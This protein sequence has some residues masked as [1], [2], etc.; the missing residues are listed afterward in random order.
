MLL[1]S[2]HSDGID[3]S[4]VSRVS[5]GT[6]VGQLLVTDDDEVSTSGPAGQRPSR[7]WAHR[8][9]R[10]GDRSFRCTRSPVRDACCS[11]AARAEIVREHVVLVVANPAPVGPESPALVELADVLIVNEL[12]AEM[13]LDFPDSKARPWAGAPCERSG[14]LTVVTL[15]DRDALVHDWTVQRLHEVPV[16]RRRLYGAASCRRLLG[17]RGARLRQRGRGVFRRRSRARPMDA[18]RRGCRE[19]PRSR[20]RSLL[21]LRT[22]GGE[23]G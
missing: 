6:R 15:G 3:A 21:A 19:H 8:A 13:L 16:I 22:W 2:M 20:S 17:E 11:F 12:E 7:R 1:T 23:S 18:V 10:A 14:C 5:D 4:A 9:P